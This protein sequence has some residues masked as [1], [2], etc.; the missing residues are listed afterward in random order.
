MQLVPGQ[1]VST[2]SRT[3]RIF[4]SMGIRN[5][6]ARVLMILVSWGE[7]VNGDR[8]PAGPRRDLAAEPLQAGANG[9]YRTSSRRP[10]PGPVGDDQIREQVHRACG[11]GIDVEA[12]TRKAGQ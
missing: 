4:C 5:T 11:L 10:D 7:S 8:Q 9:G 2:L 12:G 6:G 3:P 1:G